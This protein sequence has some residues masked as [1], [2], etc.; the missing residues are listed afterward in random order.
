MEYLLSLMNQIQ[1]VAQNL[2]WNYC[3][4]GIINGIYFLVVHAWEKH[5]RNLNLSESSLS[6]VLIKR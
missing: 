5:I 3:R 1:A 2:I 6:D 4:K